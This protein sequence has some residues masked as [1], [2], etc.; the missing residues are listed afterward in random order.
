[1]FFTPGSRGGTPELEHHGGQF[2]QS[3]FFSPVGI[4][5]IIALE[6][7]EH[8]PVYSESQLTWDHGSVAGSL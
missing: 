5:L 7:L 1:M 4:Y 2:K 6:C 8:P 3:C